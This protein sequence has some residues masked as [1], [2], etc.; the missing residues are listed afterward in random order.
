M[1]SS[2]ICFRLEQSFSN[3]FTLT[4]SQ[5]TFSF[6]CLEWVL[7]SVSMEYGD[8]IHTHMHTMNIS[9]VD[10]TMIFSA[11]VLRKKR[12]EKCAWWCVF[13]T[14]VYFFLAIIHKQNYSYNYC[15]MPNVVCHVSCIKMGKLKKYLFDFLFLCVWHITFCLS[16]YS[17][18]LSFDCDT[19]KFEFGSAF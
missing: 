2:Q 4:F 15:W 6:W 10:G 14:C 13:L 12:K 1:F 18:I 7:R 19:I 3:I 16:C 17:L 11:K 9:P 5:R 8:R